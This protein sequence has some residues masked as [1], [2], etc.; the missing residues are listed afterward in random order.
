MLPERADYGRHAQTGR[1]MVAGFEGS[2]E[3]E[4]A[5]LVLVSVGRTMNTD[6]L[7]LER[8][9]V[10]LGPSWR[11]Q[12]ERV[13]G[14][15][16]SP[17]STRRGTWW[18][19]PCSRTWLPPKGV[20]AAENAMGAEIRMDIP[21]DS[22]GHLHASRDR[23]RRHGRAR[24]GEGGARGARGQVLRPHPRQGAGRNARSKAR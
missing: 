9:G 22:G 15:E 11:D 12:G 8:I 3:E 5:D 18:A 24:G 10:E 20:A 4:R 13:D 17:A 23:R 16:R 19:S 6:G 21:R 2:D 7:G 1:E 14:D